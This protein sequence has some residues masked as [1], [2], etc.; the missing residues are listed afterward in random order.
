[1]LGSEPGYEE[2]GPINAQHG[3]VRM[4]SSSQSRI[5]VHR[6]LLCDGHIQDCNQA[7]HMASQ[8]DQT[9][10]APAVLDHTVSLTT[11]AGIA[12]C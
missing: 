5:A 3:F 2:E 7:V 4:L 11:A 12:G 10:S 9:C 8:H 6:E 1:M